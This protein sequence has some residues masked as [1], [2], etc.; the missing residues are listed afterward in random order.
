MPLVDQELQEFNEVLA[1]MDEAEMA[2]MLE[3]AVHAKARKGE[4]AM[5]A[6]YR[7]QGWIVYAP[8]KKKLTGP[9]PDAIAWRWSK[10][11]GALLEM[12]ILDNKSGSQREV[13][14]PT[15][16]SLRSLRLNLQTIID[17]LRKPKDPVLPFATEASELLKQ[18]RM[19]AIECDGQLPAGV[20]LWVTNACGKATRVNLVRFPREATEAGRKCPVVHFDP[21]RDKIDKSACA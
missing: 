11:P 18:T 7:S 9:G 4:D 19:G 6:Y 20:T 17:D 21:I 12:R 16:L 8:P 10:K 13:T 3:T 2:L 1:R 14:C 5:R 15:G